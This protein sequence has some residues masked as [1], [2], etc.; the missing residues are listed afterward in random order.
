MPWI[1]HILRREYERIHPDLNVRYANVEL[2]LGN[3]NIPTLVVQ[4]KDDEV[5]GSEHFSLI[6]QYLSNNSDIYLADIPPT[7]TVD[8]TERQTIVEGWLINK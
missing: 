5:L 1:R 2:F 3:P 8:K 6:K 7:S 4:A